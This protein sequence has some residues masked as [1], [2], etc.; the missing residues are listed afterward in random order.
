MVMAA[1]VF[2]LETKGMGVATTT[3]LKILL[4]MGI[5][6]NLTEDMMIIVIMMIRSHVVCYGVSAWM[7]GE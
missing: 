3:R 1:R 4:V 7:G 6:M 5:K 2:D